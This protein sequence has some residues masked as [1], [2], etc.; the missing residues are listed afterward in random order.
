[1]KEIR[2]HGKGG[3]GAVMLSEMLCAS[4]VYEGKHAASFPMFG[5]ERRGAP[6][7]S[8][9]RFDEEPVREKT[10]IYSPN[11][12]VIID[13]AQIHSELAYRGLLPGGVVVANSKDALDKGLHENIDV[14]GVVDA[15]MIALE[16]IGRPITNTAMLGAFAATT[17]WVGLEAILSV[18]DQYFSEDILQKN[19]Q[20]AKRGYG[21]VSVK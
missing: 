13:R 9:V 11:C 10:Q 4:L 2:F 12:V 20:A 16:E 14:V 18:L 6:V 1:M 5:F 7:A 8:F 3:E 21:E 19:L 17:K 15:T